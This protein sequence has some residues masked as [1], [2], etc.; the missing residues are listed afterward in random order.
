MD[1]LKQK[2][3]NVN[4]GPA[5]NPFDRAGQAPSTSS[6]TSQ[7]ATVGSRGS[8]FGGLLGCNNGSLFPSVPAVPVVGTTIPFR[9]YL[10]TDLMIK[11]GTT[12]SVTIRHQCITC[13]SEYQNKSLEEL[14][15]ED[16]KKG[17]KTFKFI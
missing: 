3:E 11:N 1:E 7:K 10:N 4:I 8:P 9:P 12:Q 13:M 16:Y 14:R 2:I 15:Y 5:K 6:W 17:L